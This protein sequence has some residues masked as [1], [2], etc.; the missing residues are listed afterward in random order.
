MPKEVLRSGA[1]PAATAATPKPAAPA[2]TPA[3]AVVLTDPHKAQLDAMESRLKAM[4]LEPELIAN[5]L[6]AERKK[7]TGAAA[8]PVASPTP[9]TPKV[10]E[11][12][13]VTPT[14]PKE[15]P[16]P[17]PAKAEPL[18]SDEEFA[19][20]AAATYEEGTDLPPEDPADLPAAQAEGAAPETHSDD[21]EV[22]AGAVVVQNHWSQASE[23]AIS[24][25]IDRS[26]FK[27]PQLKIVQ[28][29]GP[30]SK[31]FNQGTLIYMDETIFPPPEPDK[32]G[33]PINFIP[34]A[35]QKYFRESLQRDPNAPAGQEQRQPRNAATV[36]EV[37]RLGGTTEFSMVGDKRVKPSWAPAARCLVI[38]ERPEGNNH[39]AFSLEMEI[40]GKMRAFAPAVFFVN[41]G[42]YRA[43]VKP[44]MDATSFILC[45]GT[46]KDRRIVLEKRLWKMQ[47]AKEL[48]GENMVFNPKI[49]M[50]D[51][52]TPSDLKD[53][54]KALRG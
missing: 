5:A 15:V 24:G 51:E 12:A 19:R 25:P 1:P 41:G 21:D 37:Q 44:I 7:L 39:P 42:Q 22:P 34:V 28:G 50:I 48:S 38:I 29:S 4:N 43:F 30:L 8:K 13:K 3:S 6:A 36:E 16:A 31:K 18:P 47:V 33:P 54:A 53:Y 32:P 26:D 45:E 11:Q 14:A 46:G 52:A 27:T 2:A 17:L 49:A 9:T 35:I 23:G 10:V 40:G 20:A